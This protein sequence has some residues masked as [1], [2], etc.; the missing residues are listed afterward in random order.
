MVENEI[1]QP[2]STSAPKNGGTFDKAADFTFFISKE[3]LL[4][5]LPFFIMITMMLIFYIFIQHRAVKMQREKESL[6]GELKEL[7]AEFIT[8]K[9]D[10]VEKS[11]QSEI[12]NKLMPIGVKEL[13]TPPLK[14]EIKTNGKK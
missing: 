3:M 14:I 13:K 7:R 2:K 9:S 4:K 6:K 1:I 10:L 12:V 8:L 5:L 11:R